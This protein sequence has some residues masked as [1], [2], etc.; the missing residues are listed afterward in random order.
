MYVLIDNVGIFNKFHLNAIM[1]CKNTKKNPVWKGKEKTNHTSSLVPAHKWK[2]ELQEYSEVQKRLFTDH[3]IFRIWKFCYILYCI[4]MVKYTHKPPHGIM[5]GL[6]C[7]GESKTD[8]SSQSTLTTPS[9][10]T[11]LWRGGSVGDG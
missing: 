4:I 1:L 2:K 8:G 11:Y 9:F 10:P 7:L 6:L 3:C 5:P